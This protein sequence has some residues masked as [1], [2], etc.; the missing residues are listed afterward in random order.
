MLDQNVGDIDLDQAKWRVRHVEGLLRH[1]RTKRSRPNFA[2]HVDK[3]ELIDR[4]SHAHVHLEKEL[5][6][7]HTHSGLGA[8]TTPLPAL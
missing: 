5:R 3:L 7:L 4:L 1:H 8:S 6:S 2:W